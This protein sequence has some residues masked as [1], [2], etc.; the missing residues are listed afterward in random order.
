MQT[1]APAELTPGLFSHLGQQL[2]TGSVLRHRIVVAAVA[3]GVDAVGADGTGPYAGLVVA[4]GN[5]LS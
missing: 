5:V 3:S 2:A 1:T 4:V